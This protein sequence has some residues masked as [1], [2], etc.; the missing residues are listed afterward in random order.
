MLEDLHIK[1]VL[2]KLAKYDLTPLER[3]ILANTGTVQSLLSVIFRVPVRVEVISQ[4]ES[5]RNIIRW[6]RLVADYGEAGQVTACLAESVIPTGLNDHR[7]V[8]G[9]RER[10][11]GIGQ[12]LTQLGLRTQREI[13]GFYADETV[14]A[15]TY[16]IFADDAEYI[17]SGDYIT[18]KV[19]ILITEVFPRQVYKRIE[20]K[21]F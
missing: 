7:F 14:F 21:D 16:R 13:M 19:D 18:R 9:V 8:E 12:L 2:D 5:N 1:R 17:E 10:K 15:R 4:I 20:S 6:V 11:M 3:V